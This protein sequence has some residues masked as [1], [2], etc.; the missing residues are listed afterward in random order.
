MNQ[1]SANELSPWISSALLV[2]D[3]RATIEPLK[4]SMR[5]LAIS[6]EVC[7]EVGTAP[8]VMERRQFGAIIVDLQLGDQAQRLLQK[9]RRSQSNRT[10]VVFAISC[11]DAET[12][13]AFRDGS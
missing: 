9:V 5:Q 7:T 1:V 8:G 2:C 6:T 4:E 10:A 11:S 13:A 3:D 12:A